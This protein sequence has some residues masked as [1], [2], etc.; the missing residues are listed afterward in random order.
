MTNPQQ[1]SIELAKEKFELL[2]EDA[3]SAIRDFEYDKALREIHEMY[4]L[5]IDQASSLEKAVADVIFGEIETTQLIPILQNE[6]RISPEM[7][8]KLSI[9]VDAKI[10]RPLQEK[11]KVIQA[12]V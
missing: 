8:L 10:L 5:H 11:M 1:N 6:L 7:A 4:K 9:D 2:P 3:Q 12:Q